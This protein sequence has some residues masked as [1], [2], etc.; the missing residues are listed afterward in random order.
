MS[1]VLTGLKRGFLGRCPNCGD[2]TLFRRYLKVDPVCAVCQ[3]DNA[4][5]PADDAPPYFT[6]LIVG[7]LVIGPL[8]LFPFIWQWPAYLVLLATL[9]ALAILSLIVL[10]RVKGATVGLQWAIRRQ[11]EA[12]DAAR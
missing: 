5:Y 11:N 10:P 8:L 9:P 6:I 1:N 7:H 3:H 12:R 4:Q 2:G